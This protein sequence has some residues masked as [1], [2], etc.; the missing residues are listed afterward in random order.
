MDEI[1]KKILDILQKD[2]N[3]PLSKIADMIG[4]PKPTAY[5]RFNKMK[6][7]GTIKGFKLITSRKDNVLV[8]VA[9]AKVRNYLL[10][11][12]NSRIMENIKNKLMKRNEVLFA[13][14]ISANT[15]LISWEGDAFRPTDLDEIASYEDIENDVFKKPLE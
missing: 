4:I 6:E 5:L 11:D 8:K 2:A 9:I 3:T 14:K 13:V 1:D 10:S 7:D 15:V 12:M